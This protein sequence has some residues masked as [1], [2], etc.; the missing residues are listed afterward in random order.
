MSFFDAFGDQV[1]VAILVGLVIERWMSWRA[2][3]ERQSHLWDKKRVDS[4]PTLGTEITETKALCY[5]LRDGLAAIVK[6]VD[7]TTGAVMAVPD[8]IREGQKEHLKA[9]IDGMDKTRSELVRAI[10]DLPRA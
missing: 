6:D 9:I 7:R 1:I 3:A 2:N 5:S 8:I 10:R 4:I